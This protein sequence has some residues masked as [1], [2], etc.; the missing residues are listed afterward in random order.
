[1][2]DTKSSCLI[3]VFVLTAIVWAEEDA[4]IA[5]PGMGPAAKELE[6][7]VV[8]SEG[9]ETDGS[10]T[11]MYANG[12]HRVNFVGVTQER[13]ATGNRSFKVDV[14]W[15][16]GTSMDW[17]STPL[18]IPLYGNPVV[19]GKLYVERGAVRF[20]HA[21]TVPEAGTRGSVVSGVKVRELQDGW[22]EW[23]STSL[24]SSGDAAYIQAI[25]VFTGPPD[26]EGRTV[27]YVD[28][29]EVEAALSDSYETELK[30][31]I[32]EIEAER[33]DNLR[34]AARTLG[35]RPHKTGYGYGCGSDCLSRFG[36]GRNGG[37]L[38]AIAEV[39]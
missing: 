35:A 18:M 23:Q 10:M 21:I 20:G 26:A 1:M 3:S 39:S 11:L 4:T 2:P 14:T 27:F 36:N 29:L 13:A 17:A 9:F 32:E 6:R 5:N 28:D 7:K 31:R 38:A 24:G 22:A 15:I 30:A 8:F 12:N 37:I 33:N 16:D 19:R 25:N 34:R